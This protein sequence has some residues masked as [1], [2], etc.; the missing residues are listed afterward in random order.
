M[1][2]EVSGLPAG[3]PD[4]ATLSNARQQLVDLFPAQKL[5]STF[6]KPTAAIRARI[7]G[8]LHFDGDHPAGKV[9]PLTMRP[10]TVW[11]IHPVTKIAQR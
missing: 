10:R 9:G 11:E 8:S 3:G 5:G 4:L 6:Y 7:Q 2:S 1:T